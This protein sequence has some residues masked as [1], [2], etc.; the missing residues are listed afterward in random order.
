MFNDTKDNTGPS[1]EDNFLTVL[2]RLEAQRLG[3]ITL[4]KRQR[5]CSIHC[6][7]QSEH[8]EQQSSRNVQCPEHVP[9]VQIEKVV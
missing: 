2:F 1:T 7:A 4:N 5:V 3:Q 8:T 9:T 6:S